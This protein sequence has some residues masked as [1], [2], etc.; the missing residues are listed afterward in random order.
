MLPKEFKPDG[1][2]DLV[3]VGKNNDGGYLISKKNL[4]K[5]E[6]L[7]SLVLVTIFLLRKTLKNIKILK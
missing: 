6:Y 2:F 7:L 3:R 4:E 5:S 1:L